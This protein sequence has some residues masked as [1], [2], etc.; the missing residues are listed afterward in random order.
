MHSDCWELYLT[1]HDPL[2]MKRAEKIFQFTVDVS[3]MLPVTVG[4]VRSWARRRPE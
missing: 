1:F 2:D 3:D 4:E